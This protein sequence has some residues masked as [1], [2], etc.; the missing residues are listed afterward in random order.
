MKSSMLALVAFAA[1]ATASPIPEETYQKLFSDFVT[2]FEK[3]YDLGDF[4]KRFNIFKNNLDFIREHNANNKESYTVAMNHMG[5]ISSEEY[6]AMLGYQR[7]QLPYLRSKNVQLLNES[8]APSS[9]DWVAKGAVTPVKNQQQCGSC[10]AFST[11]GSIEGAN[12]IANGELVSLSEQ[13]LVD[14]STENNGCN[15]GLM[16]YGFEYVIKTGG[17]CTEDDYKY[18]A[19]KGSCKAKK[20]GVLKARIYGFSDVAPENEKQLKAAVA[21]GPVS[22]AIEADKSAFQFYHSGVLTSSACG[23]QLDHGVLVVGYGTEDGT[24]YWKI[25][26]SWGSSWG[27]DGFIK[28]KRGDS[29][30]S[31]GE[32]GVAAQPSYPTFK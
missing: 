18:T 20:C 31:K 26:N 25:K 3:R 9:V 12:F 32:C 19:R 17:L 22:V 7:S 16:D 11:T 8:F 27:E 13:M 29:K 24:D 14:C 5:D 4:F 6:S 21:L 1:C 10:W 28:I 30:G 15:G 2:K 23:T